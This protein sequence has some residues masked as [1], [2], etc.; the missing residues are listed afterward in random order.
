[1]RAEHHVSRSFLRCRSWFA[2]AFFFAAV[3]LGAPRSA[4][5]VGQEL[6]GERRGEGNDFHSFTLGDPVDPPF[7]SGIVRRTRTFITE[8][9]WEF[10]RNQWVRA[11]Y[12]YTQGRNLGHVSGADENCH[13]F[14]VE[15]RLEII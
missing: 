10:D 5:A 4:R 1:M 15:L 13:S 6:I 11:V 12:G 8:L 9:R 14:R 3:N 7:P 2:A